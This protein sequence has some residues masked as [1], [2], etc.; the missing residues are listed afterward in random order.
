MITKVYNKVVVGVIS[1]L[2]PLSTFIFGSCAD[3]FDQESEHVVFA[4]NNHLDNYILKCLLF[5]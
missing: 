2:F 3:F 1:F 5:G 4:E